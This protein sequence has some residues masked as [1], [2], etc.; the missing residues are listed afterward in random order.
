[1]RASR[2]HRAERLQESADK[3]RSVAGRLASE[4]SRMAE[5]IPMGQPILIGHHSERRD[6]AYRE[7]I[8]AKFEASNKAYNR[9]EYLEGRAEAAANNT[10]I[11]ADAV[12][13]VADLDARIAE[14]EQHRAEIKARD[15]A[16][17]ELSNLGANI[18]RLK[19]RRTSLAAMKSRE[20][21]ERLVGEVR[22]VEDPDIAR[23]Q[24]FYPGKPDQASRDRLK[25]NGFRWAP[26]DGSWQ[27]QLNSAGRRAA[28]EVLR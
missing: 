2:E 6:R 20:R 17:W 10:A 9:A 11:Y 19:E 28:Q 18:R 22:V 25:R 24:L 1:M 15:H 12:D 16:S 23:I 13:P 3:A 7:K 5:A 26:S 8:G 4:G 27:R 21:V 14:L